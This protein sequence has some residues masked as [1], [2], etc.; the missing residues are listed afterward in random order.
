MKIIKALLA[1][2]SMALMTLTAGLFTTGCN[3]PGGNPVSIQPLPLQSLVTPDSLKLLAENGTYLALEKQPQ[4]K[5]PLAA[6]AVAITNATAGG[7]F[8]LTGATLTGTLNQLGFGGL[9]KMAGAPLLLDDLTAATA[10]YDQQQGTNSLANN[11]NLVAALNGVAAG[12]Q[13]GIQ[14]YQQ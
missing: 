7:S 1:A 4:L 6:A 8:Q 11:T 3:T 9:A 5:Q 14:L 2:T 12:I 10:L 13:R